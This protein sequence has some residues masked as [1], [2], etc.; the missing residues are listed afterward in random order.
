MLAGEIQPDVE[1][2]RWFLRHETGAFH[3][4]LFSIFRVCEY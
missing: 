4:L 1:C 3:I 2:F